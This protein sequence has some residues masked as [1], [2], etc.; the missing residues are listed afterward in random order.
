MA[1]EAVKAQ[2]FERVSIFRP[3]LLDRGDL[4]RGMERFFLRLMPNIK[5]SQMGRMM[6]LD[7]SRPAAEVKPLAVFEMAALR[8]AAK[9]GRAP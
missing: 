1:E 6:V 4:A 3:G 2:G 9:Q 5:V 8:A 7:A